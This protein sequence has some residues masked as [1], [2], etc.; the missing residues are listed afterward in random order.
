MSMSLNLGAVSIALL[1]SVSLGA[2][3]D[4][5]FVHLFEWSWADVA[6]ECEQWLG[7]KGLSAQYL[8]V[9]TNLKYNLWQHLMQLGYQ[10]VQVSPPQEHIQ[11]SQWWTRYQVSRGSCG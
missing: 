8:N 6:L 5:N 11:G 9:D 4:G 7:P 10:A 2:V 3:Q 1:L